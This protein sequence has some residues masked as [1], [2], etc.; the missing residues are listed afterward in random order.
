MEL[1]NNIGKTVLNFFERVNYQGFVENLKYMGAGML[2]IFVVIGVI[3]IVI[4]LLQKLSK[5]E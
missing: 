4:T 1:F 3:I 5:E 2:G